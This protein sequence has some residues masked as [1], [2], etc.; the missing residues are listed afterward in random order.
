MHT[1]VL[2]LPKPVGVELFFIIFEIKVRHNSTGI[3][4]KDFIMY[5]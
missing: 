5:G 4:S 2:P 3:G 1:K